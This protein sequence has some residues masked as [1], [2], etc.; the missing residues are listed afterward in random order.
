MPQVSALYPDEPRVGSPFRTELIGADASDRFFRP[1]DTNQYK[2]VA[3][4]LGDILI[5]VGR[6]Q[7]IQAMSRRADSWSYLFAQPDPEGGIREPARGIPHSAEI[8]YVFNLPPRPYMGVVKDAQ[9]SAAMLY[10]GPTAIKRTAELMSG[11]TL[12]ALASR[13]HS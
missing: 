9:T 10:A 7:Q 2:R 11:E 8:K 13:S 4:V 12:S 3:A 6:R 5:Q 1:K